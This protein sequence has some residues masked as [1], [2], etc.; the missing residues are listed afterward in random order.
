MKP[1]RLVLALIMVAI[2]Q[3][4]AFAGDW[5]IHRTSEQMKEPPYYCYCYSMSKAN[6]LAGKPTHP[7]DMQIT[8][9]QAISKMAAYAALSETC[10][11]NCGAGT[12][13]PGTGAGAP[14]TGAGGPP[15]PPGPDHGPAPE[16][17]KLAEVG[18][19]AGFCSG[20]AAGHEGL[21]AAVAKCTSDCLE[22]YRCAK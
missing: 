1:I 3:T 7:V 14:G 5:Y 17:R 4:A 10:P 2:W 21:G 12:G 9:A 6:V 8:E 13:A 19:C 18:G 22:K 11:N 20:M 15:L 16:C